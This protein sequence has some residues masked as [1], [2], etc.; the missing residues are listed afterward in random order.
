[1]A[2]V[3]GF[4]PWIVYWILVG[5]VPFP[6]AVLVAV[7]VSALS[8]LVGRLRHVPGKSLATG[9]LVVFVVLAVLAFVIPDDVLE[10]WL[11]PLGNA[12][13][14]AVVLAGLALGRP[15]VLDYATPTVDAVTAR[16]DGFRA[17]TTGM[18]WLWAGLFALTTLISAIP[19]IVDGSAT[20]LDATDTLSI[21]CYW[22]APFVL[23]GLGGTISGAFP[24][25]FATRSAEIDARSAGDQAPVPQPDAP[26][27]TADGLTLDVAEDRRHDEPFGLVVHGTDGIDGPVELEVEGNDLV[28][29]RWRS[30]TTLPAGAATTGHP[31][32]PDGDAPIWSMRCVG[33]PEGHDPT[34]SM[35]IPPAEPW[36]VTVRARAG[37]RSAT[38]TV[39]RHAAGPGVRIETVH[40]DG[41]VAH[42]ALPAGAAP[43]A[44]L[45]AVAC[46]GGSEGGSDSQLGLAAA[47]ASRGL[48]A[49]AASWIT[50]ADA[51]KAI[52]EVPLERFAEAFDLLADHA[53]VDPARVGATGISRGSEGV[54]AAAAA[55]LVRPSALVLVSP[56]SVTWQA[57]GGGGEVPGTAS[58]TLRG[59]PVP[60]QPI[61]SGVLMPELI[62][63]AV[64]V[65]RD[66]EEHRP[67]LL[68]LRPAYEAGLARGVGDAAI[69]A[70]DVAC[71]LLILTG[72]DD[73]LWPSGPMADALLN[74]RGRVD[75]QHH[76]FPGAGHMLR[77]ALLPTEAPWSGGIAFGG[78][79]AGLAAA[80]HEATD[81]ATAYLVQYTGASA[82]T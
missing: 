81:L 78:T 19:P 31:D 75:D 33:A 12:G 25:W 17:I 28:G 34:P 29:R 64:H 48:V 6:L 36:R 50:E 57:I 68:R 9:T 79:A 8:L 60:W 13:L 27:D 32:T 39:L 56:S 16:T 76:A 74:R 22:V 21:L 77:F 37:G 3:V 5:N 66:V 11:Q 70:E 65:R 38:R 1:M 26:P 44:D 7:A 43:G 52:Q 2:F 20:M 24:P 10:R 62:R 58:W 15:F 45:A 51:A 14:L 82:R 72:D 63:N 46:F 47:L 49:L 53:A 67:T 18:T 41:R 30:T 71:P 69:R 59:A 42:L 4:L 61:P 23:L 80:Q 54:L 40:L 55:G 35:F 73:A